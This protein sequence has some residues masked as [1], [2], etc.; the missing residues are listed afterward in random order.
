VQKN[1]I[2]FVSFVSIILANN[3][4]ACC[5]CLIVNASMKSLRTT[6][7]TALEEI[8]RKA[9]QR[10]KAKVLKQNERYLSELKTVKT[11]IENGITLHKQMFLEYDK[12]SYT[13]K[14][15]NLIQGRKGFK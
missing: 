10:F 1:K 9:D 11:D 14:K 13:I 3:L 15:Q 6:T 12:I 8:N 4:S 7:K 2:V 5:G